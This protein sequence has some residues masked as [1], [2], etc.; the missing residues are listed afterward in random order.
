MSIHA[1]LF[2]CVIVLGL[3]VQPCYGMAE[4]VGN[5]TLRSKMSLG[6]RFDPIRLKIDDDL[7]AK[8]KVF[9]A[10]GVFIRQETAEV[11]ISANLRS[12][13]QNEGICSAN[14]L[15]TS[16]CSVSGDNSSIVKCSVLQNDP[17]GHEKCSVRNQTSSC[18]VM[19]SGF[20]SVDRHEEYGFCSII[21]LKNS[22]CS[23]L[24]TGANSKCSVFSATGG[25]SVEATAQD[26]SG[27]CSV[28]KEPNNVEHT[29]K[30]SVLDDAGENATCS[31][32]GGGS[33]TRKCSVF[34]GT[35]GNAECTVFGTGKNVSQCSVHQQPQGSTDGCSVINADGSVTP[36]I[37]GK[38]VVNGSAGGGG[39]GPGLEAWWFYDP[40]AYDRYLVSSRPR[41]FE[42]AAATML[43]IG[44]VL[45]LRSKP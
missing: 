18:S 41:G 37:A 9:V 25:C 3:V 17:S 21:S 14:N 33:G 4:S 24:N 43:L 13:D 36:P 31:A 1:F 20:C 5:T 29:A 39:G 42:L 26:K 32:Y 8:P 12:G 34:H 28:R 23:V 16:F 6:F 40:S 19:H 2:R 38:C 44:L 11:V 15:M 22:A 7:C 10:T 27:T 35:K 30:C 45:T